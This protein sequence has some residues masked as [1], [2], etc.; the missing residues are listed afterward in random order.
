MNR[1]TVWVSD[2][3]Q[4]KPACTV[5]EAGQKIEILDSIRRGIVLQTCIAKP[6]ALINFAVTVKLVCT[7]VFAYANRWFSDVKK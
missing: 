5:T 6:T 2:Q 4:H 1:P 3:V 7:F